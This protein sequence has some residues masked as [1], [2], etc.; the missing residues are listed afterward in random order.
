MT[1]PK[2]EGLPSLLSKQGLLRVKGSDISDNSGTTRGT[3]WD[4]PMRSRAYD[5]Q[6]HRSPCVY[7]YKIRMGSSSKPLFQTNAGLWSPI[8]SPLSDNGWAL[9]PSSEAGGGERIKISKEKGSVNGEAH[10]L[11]APP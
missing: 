2:V 9:G 1:G 8:P 3:N 5:H 10:L 11:E 7:L 6:N 4:C